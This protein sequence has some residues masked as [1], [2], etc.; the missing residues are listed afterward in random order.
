MSTHG[1]ADPRLLE[2]F[3]RTDSSQQGRLDVTQL[4]RYLRDYRQLHFS[5]MSVARLVRLADKS[6]TG[7]LDFAG[8]A[9]YGKEGWRE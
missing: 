6:K 4:Q 7:M 9:S 5:L 2:V 1:A 8:F 3:Q